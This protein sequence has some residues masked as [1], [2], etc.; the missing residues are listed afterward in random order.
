METTI[1]E[2]ALKTP[3]PER[4]IRNL[5]RLL[6]KSD[7]LRYLPVED[8]KKVVLLFSYSQFLADFCAIN[9]EVLHE[10]MKKISSPI[11]VKEIFCL[12]PK[13]IKDRQEALRILRDLRKR[14]YLRLTLRFL[15]G[16]SDITESM[17][18]LTILAEA[19]LQIAFDYAS[20]LIRERYGDIDSSSVSFISLGKLGAGELNYSSDIDLISLYKSRDAYS[21]GILTP[22]GVRI[23]RIHSHEY[24]CKLTETVSTLLSTRTEDG[25]AYRVDLR[26]RP[27]GE[28]GDLSLPLESSLSYYESWG[29]TWERMALIRARPVAGDISLGETFTGSIVP[30][31]WKKSVDYLDIEEIRDM[32]RK[33]DSI[34]DIR[35]IK[36][37]YGG[38]REIEFFVQTFQLLKGGEIESLRTPKLIEAIGILK[39]EGFIPETDAETLIKTYLFLRRLEH[40]LQMRDDL[41][42]HSLPTASDEV[43]ILSRKMGYEDTKEFISILKVGRLKVRDMYNSILGDGRVIPVEGMWIMDEELTDSALKDYLSFKGLSDPAKAMSNIIDLRNLSSGKTLRERN[44][45]RRTIPVFVNLILTTPGKDRGLTSFTSFIEKIGGYESY[46]DLLSKRIDT[47]KALTNAFCYSSYLTS[48]LLRLENL[49]S[50]FEYPDIRHDYHALRENFYILLNTSQDPPNALRVSKATEELKAGMLFV[51]KVIDLH[52]LSRILTALADNILRALI[53][54]LNLSKGFAIIGLGRFGSGN[55]IFGSDLDLLFIS[56]DIGAH[57]AAE[58]II[59]FLSEHMEKGVAYRID[60]RLRPDGSKGIL[61]NDIDGYREYYL[62]HAHPWE[63]QALLKA[64]AVAGEG[65]LLKAFHQ[66]K[67]EIV[68]EKGREVTPS[69]IIEMRRRILKRITEDNMVYDIKHGRGGIDELEYAIQYLQLQNAWRYP[70]LLTF[71]TDAAI[72]GLTRHGI[73]EI[74]DGRFLLDSLRFLRTVE[75]ILR[76]NESESFRIDS[77]EAELATRYLDMPSRSSLINRLRQTFSNALKIVNKIFNKSQTL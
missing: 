74:K 36:R 67:M 70:D 56:P 2:E 73:I 39:H 60:T 71:S 30:F 45:L 27:G 18:E 49:E 6:G 52:G 12:S 72:K 23:N 17:A 66:L 26:L 42:T 11:E 20:L 58:E 28:R 50:I 63:V 9:P 38:I 59:R 69:D 40:I 21:S 15:T 35:D 32:K 5:E 1:R 25:I 64:R 10:E 77:V 68:K 75:I 31:V 41:Q 62:K 51:S 53:D 47:V 65:G 76:L 33:I 44:L 54:Y 37:G 29:K 48:L 19:I 24:F 14:F 3:D 8:I 34:A 13:I 46:L 7:L 55:L 57:R 22:S 43:S 4:S 16:L 61:I